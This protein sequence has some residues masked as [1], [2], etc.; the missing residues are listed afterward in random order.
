MKKV[1]LAYSGGLDTS[2]CTSLLKERYDFGE[3]IAVIVDVGQPKDDIK[4]ARERA[5]MLADGSYV[6]DAKEEFVEEYV[7]PL[8]KANGCYEGYVLGTAIARP[9]IAKKSWKLQRRK[10]RR[11]LRT[12]V[13]ERETISSDLISSSLSPGSTLSLQSGN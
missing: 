5:E 11:R 12:A 10:R 6:I 9:L 7:F 2:I 4:M 3:V 13:R 8:V 1:V